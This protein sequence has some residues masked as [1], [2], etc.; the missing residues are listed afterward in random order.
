MTRVFHHKLINIRTIY[1]EIYKEIYYSRLLKCERHISFRSTA[2][3]DAH[4]VWVCWPEARADD[5]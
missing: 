1:L 4:S 2:H 3:T 5:V